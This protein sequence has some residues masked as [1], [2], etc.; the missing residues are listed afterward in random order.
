MLRLSFHW[1]Q[2]YKFEEVHVFGE[3]DQSPLVNN[4]LHNSLRLN[5]KLKKMNKIIY[6]AAKNGHLAILKYLAEIGVDYS[7]DGFLAIHWAARYGHLHIIKYFTE[8]KLY[9]PTIYELDVIIFH[10]KIKSEI[11][12]YLLP[13]Y[14]NLKSEL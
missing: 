4:L 8:E 9:L 12:K 3:I 1:L 10:C 13:I 6:R 14:E 7:K 2:S 5:K 11:I